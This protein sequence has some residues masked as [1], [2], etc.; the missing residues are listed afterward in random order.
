VG[1]RADDGQL[2]VLF[3]EVGQL[4]Q[5]VDVDSDVFALGF[6]G[7]AGV[8]GGNEDFLDAGVLGDFPGQ[9]VFTAAAADDQNFHV[10]TSVWCRSPK[11]VGAISLE[12]D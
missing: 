12:S 9:G 1:F 6:S 8:A 7:G 3:G 11:L 10:K 5:G 2:H 4:L